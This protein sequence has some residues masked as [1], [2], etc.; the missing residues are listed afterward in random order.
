MQTEPKVRVVGKCCRP[1]A[2]PEESHRRELVLELELD[3]LNPH[4]QSRG[5]LQKFKTYADCPA[6]RQAQPSPRLW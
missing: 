4:L 2:T 6:W 1:P 3:V 5:F